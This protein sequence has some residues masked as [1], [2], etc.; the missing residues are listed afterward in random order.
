MSRLIDADTLIREMHNIIL[1][2]GEDRHT[3]Y[4]VIERQSII[5]AVE[6]RH[7]RWIKVRDPSEILMN[8]YVCDKCGNMEVCESN[9]CPHCGAK[10]KE[11]ADVATYKFVEWE[12][13]E[14]TC[15]RDGDDYCS[16]GVRKEPDDVPLP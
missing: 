3:F 2:D 10:M 12:N 1:E 8:Y 9:Y 7:G 14:R 16:H 11:E 6:V 5:D 13:G 15:E 4:E